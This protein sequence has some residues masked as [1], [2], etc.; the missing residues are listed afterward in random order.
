MSASVPNRW[1]FDRWKR[2]SVSK[3]FQLFLLPFTV[4][5]Q[6]FCELTLFLSCQLTTEVNLV[7][8]Q[9]CLWCSHGYN[10]SSPREKNTFFGSFISPVLACGCVYIVD[11]GCL[12]GPSLLSLLLCCQT[13]FC[14]SVTSIFHQTIFWRNVYMLKPLDFILNIFLKK[15]EKHTFDLKKIWRK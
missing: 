8:K 9:M 6:C 2:C 12:T 5:K 10:T 7:L 4:D 1:R 3:H 11:A 15:K 14:R 13:A